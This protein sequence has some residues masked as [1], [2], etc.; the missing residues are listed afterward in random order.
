MYVPPDLSESRGSSPR[1][2]AVDEDFVYWT[3]N[4]EK[5]IFKIDR[6]RTSK[7]AMVAH[8]GRNMGPLVLVRKDWASSESWSRANCKSNNNNNQCCA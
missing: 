3:D 8:A 1:S 5:A 2:I 4:R 6:E 7:V